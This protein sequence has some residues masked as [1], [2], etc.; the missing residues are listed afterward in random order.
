MPKP[1]TL[2]GLVNSRNLRALTIEL[3]VL[4]A[5]VTGLAVYHREIYSRVFG[6]FKVTVDELAAIPSLDSEFRRYFVLDGSGLVRL[7]FGEEIVHRAARARDRAQLP[8]L[9]RP[10]RQSAHADRAIVRACAPDARRRR[11][12]AAA[13]GGGGSALRHLP[14]CGSVRAWRP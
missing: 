13:R 2:R 11:A 3:V 6:P 7:P 12:G 4:A 8:L 5:V 1:T 10:A 14:S 9:F